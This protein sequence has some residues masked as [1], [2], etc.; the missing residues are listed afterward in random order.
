MTELVGT[1]QEESGP[2]TLPAMLAPQ[3]AAW[4]A[5]MD[6]H[7]RLPENWTLVGGQMVHLHCAERDVSPERP[8]DD[9]DTVLDVRASSDML[10]RFTSALVD[11]GFKPATSGDGLQHR[12]HRDDGAQIDV[13]LPDGIG[14]RASSRRG[15]GGAPT[16]ET[17]GGSQALARS[18]SIEVTVAGRTGHVRRPDLVGALVMKA[19]A[20][21]TTREGDSAK[22][23]HRRDFV[24]LAGMV[25]AR[26]FRDTDLR[27]KDRKRLRTIVA[28][29]RRDRATMLSMEGAERALSR[30]ERAAGLGP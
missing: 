29:V 26:D 12:W 2:V 10:D 19:A 20:H 9:A 7:E 8:T 21:G 15:A 18:R 27:P 1:S 25:S 24:T 13:L 30:V 11:M 23:R 22:G 5:L 16:L 4:H 28:A 3:E 6:L 17:P 14:E